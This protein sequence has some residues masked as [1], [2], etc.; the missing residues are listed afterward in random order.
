[1]IA[2][3]PVYLDECVDYHLVTALRAR[4]YVVSSA[5]DHRMMQIDDEAQLTFATAHGWM[6]LSHNER[7][8]RQL[9]RAFRARGLA[10]GGIVVVTRRSSFAQLELRAAMLIDWI[11]SLGAHRSRYFK[12][13]MLQELLETSGQFAGYH[14]DEVQLALGRA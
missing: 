12:W 1:M 7:D 13:G 5:L 6:L 2:A 14:E 10:H 3:P 9:H 11:G 4:G 8:F